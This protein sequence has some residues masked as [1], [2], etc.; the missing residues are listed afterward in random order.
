MTSSTEPS[1][2]RSPQEIEAD[3]AA[4]RARFVSTLDE[5][6]VRMQPDELGQELSEIG[7]SAL[8]ATVQTAKEWMGLSEDSD[9]PRPEFVGA[10][11]GAGLA[12]VVLVVRSRRR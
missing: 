6:S 9:G 1:K 4:T 2:S 10:V 3:L 7:V 12:V 5:L 11:A 8:E